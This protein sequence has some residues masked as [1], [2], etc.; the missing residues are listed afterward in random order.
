MR[1]YTRY[2][3]N[4]KQPLTFVVISKH[5]YVLT[6]ADCQNSAAHPERHADESHSIELPYSDFIC[7]IWCSLQ[8]L[9]PPFTFSRPPPPFSQS[10]TNKSANC[11]ATAVRTRIARQVASRRRTEQIERQHRLQQEAGTSI[12]TGAIGQIPENQQP[13][14]AET[15][16]LHIEDGVH[17]GDG[18]AAM[19]KVVN[20]TEST[21]AV[22]SIITPGVSRIEKVVTI[23]GTEVE[24]T[25]HIK[26]T[27]GSAGQDIPLEMLLVAVDKKARRSSRLA[28]KAVDIG[29][30]VGRVPGAEAGQDGGGGKPRE[31]ALGVFSTVLKALTV[32]NSRRKDLFILS[33][34]GKEVVAPH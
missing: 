30:I 33:Y 34:K 16:S 2:R 17:G 21:A 26:E 24:L 19:D 18:G 31:G 32:F 1:Y 10:Q 23:D 22:V 25:A 20:N 14:S 7:S 6:S 5:Q 27:A 12:R 15:A 3:I 9:E 4:N 28:L 8:R 13:V 11:L 29:N